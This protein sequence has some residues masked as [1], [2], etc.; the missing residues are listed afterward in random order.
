MQYNTILFADIAIVDLLL[1]KND[2]HYKTFFIFHRKRLTAR[3]VFNEII[4]I[5]VTPH[6]LIAAEA[7]LEPSL[8]EPN[9]TLTLSVATLLVVPDPLKV[10]YHAYSISG[11]SISSA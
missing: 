5:A 3:E 11:Y 1:F 7:P 10:K 6:R 9:T 4:P 2:N 8:S